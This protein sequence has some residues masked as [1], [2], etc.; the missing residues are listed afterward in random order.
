[1]G[2]CKQAEGKQPQDCQPGPLHAPAW[3]HD[4]EVHGL[5]W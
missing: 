1:M 2:L 5:T 4:S 3:T